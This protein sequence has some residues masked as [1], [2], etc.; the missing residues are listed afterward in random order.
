MGA[1]QETAAVSMAAGFAWSA[2]RPA[3]CTVTHGPG[4]S[5]ALTGLRS[6]VRDR[7]A[8]VLIVGD[9]RAEPGW[10]A[11][12]VDHGQ[13]L[14][15]TEAAVLDCADPAGLAAAVAD[16]FGRAGAT[17]A[18]VV[19]NIRAELLAAPAVPQRPADPAPERAPVPEPDDGAVQRA[20]AALRAARRPLV[21]AG[22]G[23]LWAGAGPA[24]RELAERSGA[25]LATTLPA[26]GLFRGDPF[27]LGVCG[28]YSTA[29]T[30]DL[31]AE[32]D[33]ALVVGAGLGG[34]TTDRDTLLA[35]SRVV[36]CD[37]APRPDARVAVP[38]DAAATV[39]RLLAAVR[40]GEPRR[41]TG[42]VAA[43]IATAGD[44]ADGTD[45][46]GLDP[47]LVLRA[48]DRALPADRQV[49]TDVGHFTTF[50]SQLVGAGAGRYLPALGFAAVGLSVATGIGAAL[51][52]AGPTLVVVGTAAR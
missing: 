15:W 37:L 41:R 10:S 36:H 26:K 17:R 2:G 42:E 49:V 4:L 23:A 40:G 27:D 22:R 29:V 5:N 38:G 52:R 18:P 30:R 7:L 11:Q 35:A 20:A 45:A 21:L 6:A 3:V 31:V 9:I 51:G 19:L 39:D 25:L 48:V 32:S 50:P 34:Y 44:F 1:R 13:M 43:R 24:L 47:R 12:R 8:V 16:A 33:L 46:G 28:G 14:G